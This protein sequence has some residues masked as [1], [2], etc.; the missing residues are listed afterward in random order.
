MR[1]LRSADYRVM[2]WK[3]GLGSTTELVR[4]PD[5][6]EFDWRV[7]IADVTEDSAFSRFHGIDR[8]IV[9]I[10]GSGMTLRHGAVAVTLQTLQPYRFAGD[11][12]T[13]CSLLSGSIRDFNVL[14]RRGSCEATLTVH[15]SSVTAAATLLYCVSGKVAVTAERKT[16]QLVAGETLLGESRGSFSAELKDDAVAIVVS[17]T[18]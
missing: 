7:S 10:E 8:I 15:R 14:T 1:L 18:D 4:T 3:N 5:Q 6:E 12:E 9:A 11:L 16:F 13:Y 17:I 2:P